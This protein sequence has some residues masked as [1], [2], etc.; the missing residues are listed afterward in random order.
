MH[1]VR[2][3]ES[4]T[5]GGSMKG[6]LAVVALVLGTGSSSACARETVVQSGETPPASAQA[7]NEHIVGDGE[8]HEYAS[9]DEAP[10]FESWSERVLV[11]SVVDPK[12]PPLQGYVDRDVIVPPP[13]SELPEI[14][15]VYDAEVGGRVIA[16]WGYSLGWIDLASFEAAGFDIVALKAD[17]AR[18]TSAIVSGQR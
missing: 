5:V 3:A 15:D 17:K 12:A 16:K 2:P 1:E 7:T 10:G 8:S 4:R 13:G 18:E 6:T 14:A 11:G 9:W